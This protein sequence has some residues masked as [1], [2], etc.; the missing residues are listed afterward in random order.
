M[1]YAPIVD[2][3]KPWLSSGTTAQG[4]GEIVAEKADE[5]FEQAFNIDLTEEE[6]R[7]T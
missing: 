4:I 3:N 1:G 6:V 7:R 2:K 5:L